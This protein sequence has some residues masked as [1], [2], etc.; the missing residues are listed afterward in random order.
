LKENGATTLD[1]NL[2]KDA[3]HGIEAPP[4]DDE[5]SPES[6]VGYHLAERFSSPERLDHEKQRL[7][8][9]LQCFA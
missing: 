4:S 8:S 7:Y 5:E 2:V 3:A 9:P 1:W 6:Y